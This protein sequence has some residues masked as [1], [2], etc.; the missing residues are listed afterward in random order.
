MRRVLACRPL[1]L[2][3][4]VLGLVGCGPGAA[5][6]PSPV[7]TAPQAPAAPAPAPTLAAPAARPAL[8][9]FRWA[10]QAPATDAGLFIALERGYFAEQGVELEYLPFA[11]ASDM[12][13]AL[14]TRQA[15]GGGLAVNAATINAVARGVE[16][17][18]VADKGSMPPGYGWQAFLVRK[19]LVESG[20]FRG[21]A[22]LKGL[23]FAT[24]PPIN[25]S[26]GYPALDAVLREGG[27][28]QD[29]L[30]IEMMSF[31]DLNAALARGAIDVAISIEPLVT[32]AV[33]Q[34]IAV[35]WRGL[36]EVRPGQQIGVVG[37][38]PSITVDRPD[39]GRAFM[40]AYLRG[41]RDYNRA[42]TTG[43][44][45]AEVVAA[46]AK[47]STIKDPAIIEAMAPIGLHPDGRVNIESLLEDQR[48]YVEKGTV[49]APIDM[50]QLV[51]H[52]YVEA[53]LRVL[54]R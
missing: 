32:A 30:R 46:I 36:D 14:A 54:G 22:D 35:R 49:P 6:A 3:A 41:V 37:Y 53:A 29:D 40:V 27:L 16:I 12:V 5:P 21:P 24:T 8:Q 44:G 1:V 50:Y 45:R 20:R 10:G 17:K 47:H 7:P 15:D 18:V 19:D 4:L 43:A 33:D 42:F 2:L 9:P 34:G 48:F 11:S 26:A 23:V 31:P 52:S 28:T 51:D 25:A 38:G 39:L 13:P